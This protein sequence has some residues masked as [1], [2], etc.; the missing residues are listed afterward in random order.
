MN[1]WMSEK[2][3]QTITQYLNFDNIMLEYGSGGSTLYFSK[4]V[5]EYYS[6]EHNLEWYNKIVNTID[7]LPNTKIFHIERD[8]H[9][10]GNSRIIASSL[11]TLEQSSRFQDFYKYIHFPAQLNTKFDAVL[12]DGRAR[13]ECGKFIKSY[14]TPNAYIFVHDYWPRKHYHVLA[15]LY[16]LVDSVKSGQSLAVFRNT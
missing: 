4:L 15:D 6:I 16:E 3:I 5:K 11:D 13:P 2:E 8:L 12:I 7:A 9:T 10:S 14:L 1:T